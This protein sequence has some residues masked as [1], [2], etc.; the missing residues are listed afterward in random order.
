MVDNPPD[1]RGPNEDQLA[2]LAPGHVITTGPDG[3][4][5]FS[6]LSA[7][8]YTLRAFAECFG[9]VTEGAP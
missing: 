8:E 9:P 5:G 1:D 2:N 4:Y 6:D 7:G 3:S